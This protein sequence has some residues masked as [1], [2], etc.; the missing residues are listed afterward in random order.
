MKTGKLMFFPQADFD[1]DR[2]FFDFWAL[3]GDETGACIC[4]CA[5]T[6]GHDTLFAVIDGLGF[7]YQ[8]GIASLE[9]AEKALRAMPEYEEEDR[10]VAFAPRDDEEP[11]K[12]DGGNC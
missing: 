10:P 1:R 12:L 11:A 3:M 4:R 5:D 7:I 2:G 9:E 8:S 6:A